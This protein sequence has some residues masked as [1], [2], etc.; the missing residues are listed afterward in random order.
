MSAVTVGIVG[1][2]VSG[3]SSLHR[4]VKKIIA[5]E[6]L[7]KKCESIHL[8]DEESCTGGPAWSSV[9]S[10]VQLFNLP[11]GVASLEQHDFTG[12]FLQWCKGKGHEDMS[13]GS[14]PAR[15]LFGEYCAEFLQSTQSLA[16]SN[17]INLVVHTNCR[18]TDIEKVNEID[19]KITWHDLSRDEKS[20]DTLIVNAA[21]LCTGEILLSYEN[22]IS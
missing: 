10:D 20:E 2:G 6:V 13:F 8:W 3:I 4:L 17:D 7:A 16:R 5:D 18:V 21:L 1:G 14:Y 9:N 22:R 12:P 15:S 11:A 19:L